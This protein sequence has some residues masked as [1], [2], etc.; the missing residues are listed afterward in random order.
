MLGKKK[1]AE[2]THSR[3]KVAAR[4]ADEPAFFSRQIA[5][6]RRF[7]LRLDG[8]WPEDFNLVCGGIER[9]ASDF[10]IVRDDF[11]YV[12]VEFVA[13]GEG[14]LVLNNQTHTLMTG[15][16]FA[17]GPGVAHDIRCRPD[18]PMTKYFVNFGGPHVSKMLV[19][20]GPKPGEIMQS[21]APEHIVEIFE[22]LIDAGK[23]D[24]PFRERIC[25]AIGEHLLLRLAESAVPLGAIGTATF[26]TFQR[27]RQWVD[28]N[29]RQI[30]R[31]GEIALECHV[32]EAY[33][34]RLFKRYAHHSPWQY[35]L[36]LKMRDAAQRLQ[37]NELRV[38]EVAYEFGFADPFQFS[39]TF[40]RVFGISPRSFMQLQR[41]GK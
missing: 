8:P 25:Q 35:I 27:C 30:E 2:T 23:R 40:H 36:R 34:C 10:H 3:P 32:D 11:P 13:Q 5:D 28:R 37:S 12:A 7:Y 33:L 19:S 15:A 41:R 9:C 6:A 22:Q 18:K 21:S 26:E 4:A 24:T 17:Y 31:L 20:P 39:R 38:S 1:A 16:V 14:I 29:Y